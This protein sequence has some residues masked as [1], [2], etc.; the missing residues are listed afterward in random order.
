MVRSGLIDNDP[1]RR[2]G[3]DAASD[4]S[5]ASACSQTWF[6]P[7]T[8]VRISDR[9]GGAMTRVPIV[10]ISSTSDDLKDHRE[11][12]ARAALASGFYPLMME[13][14]PAAGHRPTLAACLE[15]VDKA[16]VVVVLVAHRYGWVPDDPSNRDAKSITW[17]ECHRAWNVTGKEV[18]AFLVEPNC[19]WPVELREDYRLIEDKNLPTRKYNQVRTEVKRNEEKLDQ[20][21]KQLSGYLRATFTDA[22]SV[23]PW[24]PRRSGRGNRGTNRQPRPLPTGTPMP[25]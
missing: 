14:F 9:L 12:A 20:F 7:R 18:L 17:L 11:Q 13:Y 21:K 23:R 3:P 2:K 6:C 15:E 22:A 1:L 19:D 24:S 25:T 8:S 4:R 16:E 10:F 5:G